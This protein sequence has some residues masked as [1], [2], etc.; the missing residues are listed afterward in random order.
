MQL[1]AHVTNQRLLIIFP[2]QSWWSH[3]WHL[4]HFTLDSHGFESCQHL[5]HPI[6]WQSKSASWKELGISG[7]EVS[8]KHCSGEFSVFFGS[9]KKSLEVKLWSFQYIHCFLNSS[10]FQI[11]CA[12]IFNSYAATKI[13]SH[14][15]LTG[16]SESWFWKFKKSLSRGCSLCVVFRGRD[17]KTSPFL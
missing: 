8:D 11:S 15:W 9:Y 4:L 1:R 16:C 10:S 7:S 12:E 5:L 13:R 3:S 14:P 17:N 2:L 6:H